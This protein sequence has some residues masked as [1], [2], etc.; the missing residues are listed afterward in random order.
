MEVKRGSNKTWETSSP[1]VWVSMGAKEAFVHGAMSTK[2]QWIG[3]IMEITL[4]S[5]LVT[6]I[7]PEERLEQN[8]RDL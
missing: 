2:I 7:P 3:P 8:L 6:K 5:R 1:A 4:F